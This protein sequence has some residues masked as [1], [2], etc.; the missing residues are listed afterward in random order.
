MR[1]RKN[2][3]EKNA[4]DKENIIKYRAGDEDAG[5]AL[6]K[7]YLRYIKGQAYLKAQKSTQEVN[8]EEFE[9]I[10]LKILSDCIRNFD[11]N[12]ATSFASYFAISLKRE[13]NRHE[14][15]CGVVVHADNRGIISYDKHAGLTDDGEEEEVI[16]LPDTKTPLPTPWHF[17]VK[18]GS[19]LT[20]CPNLTKELLLTC[21]L[22]KKALRKFLRNLI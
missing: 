21:F 22:K 15:F 1:Q 13:F 10:G 6:V 17:P 8:V 16:Q 20:A 9:S 3:N 11:T 14:I 5:N 7:E 19:G 2:Y 12:N 18:C 4:R